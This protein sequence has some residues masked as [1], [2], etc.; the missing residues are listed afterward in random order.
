MALGD[1]NDSQCVID[2]FV[3]KRT[4][5]GGERDIHCF[6]LEKLYFAKSPD[7]KYS[8]EYPVRC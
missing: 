6:F 2:G 7:I 8:S 3:A 1:L 4:S 5:Q